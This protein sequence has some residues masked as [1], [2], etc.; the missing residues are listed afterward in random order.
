MNISFFVG[1][2]RPSVR[3]YS[4]N[5]YIPMIARVLRDLKETIV[6][7]VGKRKRKKSPDFKTERPAQYTKEKI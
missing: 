3:A 1:F 4:L 7:A 2:S 6:G 5:K